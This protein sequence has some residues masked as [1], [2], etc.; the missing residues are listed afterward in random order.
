MKPVYDRP[1]FHEFVTQAKDE[2]QA[3]A[4]LK[5][6]DEK[7]MLG[8]LPLGGGKLLWCA[9]EMNTREEIDRAAAI[10]KEVLEA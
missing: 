7:D 5:A 6:L 8:G 4:I 10:V 9:T 2:E 3:Q 1:F